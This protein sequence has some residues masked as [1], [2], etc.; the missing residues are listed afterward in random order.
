LYGILRSAVAL[1]LPRGLG[2]SGRV[3]LVASCETLEGC[4]PIGIVL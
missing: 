4:A 3:S 2:D 1:V